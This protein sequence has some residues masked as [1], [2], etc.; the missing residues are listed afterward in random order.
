MN[1]REPKPGVSIDSVTADAQDSLNASRKRRAAKARRSKIMRRVV[2]PLAIAAAVGGGI[3][4]HEILS[5]NDTKTVTVKKA[6]YLWDFANQLAI[7][8]GI[9]AN[10]LTYKIRSLN[11]GIDNSLTPGEVLVV[12]SEAIEQSRP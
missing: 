12:P 10:E 8:R 1:D 9:D 5:N 4:A 11:P 2:T 3:A 7:Q 6:E